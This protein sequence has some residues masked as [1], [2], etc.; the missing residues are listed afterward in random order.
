MRLFTHITPLKIGLYLGMVAVLGITFMVGASALNIGADTSPTST[1]VPAVQAPSSSCGIEEDGILFSADSGGGPRNQAC[2]KNKKDGRLRV[3]GNVQLNRI[4]GPNVQPNN[5]ADAYG[6]CTDCQTLAVALQLN[7][8]KRGA[9]Q[10]TPYNAAEAINYRCTRCATVAFA[11]QYVLPVD[12]PDRV[13]ENVDRLAKAMD[14]ELRAIHAD[15]NIGLPEAVARIDAVIAD[16]RELAANLDDQRKQTADADSPGAAP[17][18]SPAG[19]ATA[20]VTA[21]ATTGAAAAA[22]SPTSAATE[23]PP[24]ATSVAS[25]SPAA[26]SAENSATPAPS[27]ATATPPA[28]SPTVA[29]TCTP[30]PTATVPPASV[31]PPAA[32]Q[33]PG[34]PC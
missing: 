26:A 30:T 24:T 1:P 16:F 7:L 2:L 20:V 13:P 29:T 22:A 21:T 10:V 15:K 33:T 17:T 32:T 4:N 31:T 34:P 12:D 6:S 18:G 9:P 11:L 5:L 28:A 3:R 14:R 19:S 25:P 8:Y 27:P 23:A